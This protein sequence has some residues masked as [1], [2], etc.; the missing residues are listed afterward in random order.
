MIIIIIIRIIRIRIIIITNEGNVDVKYQQ[1]LEKYQ[2][3]AFEIRER[4]SRFMMTVIRIVI[5]CLGGGGEW[6]GKSAETIIKDNNGRYKSEMCG[7]WD[8]ENFTVWK[9]KSKEYC[10]NSHRRTGYYYCDQCYLRDYQ[11]LKV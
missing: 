11:I 5:W 10:L 9:Q 7:E 8:A 3:L 6:D 1:K 2:Q 4:R